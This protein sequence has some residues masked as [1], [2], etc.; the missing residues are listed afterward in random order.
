MEQRHGPVQS[1]VRD[2]L[3]GLHASVEAHERR[4]ATEDL[5]AFLRTTLQAAQVRTLILCRSNLRA[6]RAVR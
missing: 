1:A 3:Y 4:R 5:E 6:R 2:D